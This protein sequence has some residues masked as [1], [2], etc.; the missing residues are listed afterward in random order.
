[1]LCRVQQSQF[2]R[3]SVSNILHVNCF[4]EEEPCYLSCE[5]L[6][7]H[8]QDQT[9]TNEPERWA[10]ALFEPDDLLE[11]RCFPSRQMTTQQEPLKFLPLSTRKRYKLYPW[12]AASRIQDVVNKLLLFNSA[13]G[14]V[15]DWGLWNDSE[16]SWKDIIKLN[17]ISLNVYCSANPRKDQGTKNED[18]ILARSL[19]ADCEYTNAIEVRRKCLEIGL[20]QQ[21]LLVNSGHGI[22][23]YWRLLE[24]IT[25]LEL[26]REFQQ[27]LILALDSDGKVKDPA[28][29]MRL[30]GF[31]NINGKPADCFIVEEN[32]DCRYPLKVFDEVLPKLPRKVTSQRKLHLNGN[33]QADAPCQNVSKVP[34]DYVL[35]RALAYQKTVEPVEEGQRNAIIFRLATS[36]AEYFDLSLDGL[37]KVTTAYNNRLSD[38]LDE[39]ELMLVTEKGH[40]HVISKE[41]PLGTFL[42]DIQIEQLASTDGPEMKLSEWRK[43]MAKS[44]TDS[45]KT[46]K[47]INFDRSPTGAG[48][49]TA[50]LAAITQANTSITFVPTH[51]ACHELVEKL[52]AEGV[53]AAA[54]PQINADTCKRFGNKSNPGEA[55]LAQQAGLDVGESI[56]PGC[57]FFKQC[58]YQEQRAAARNAL[59]AIATQA[60]A[61]HSDFHLAEDKDIIFIHEDARTLLRPLVKV[62]TQGNPSLEDLKNVFRVVQETICISNRMEDENKVDFANHLKVATKRLIDELKDVSMVAKVQEAH[63]AG[64]ITES[65]R[66]IELPLMSPLPRPDRFDYVM[67]RAMQSEGIRPHG[68]ALRLCLGYACGELSHLIA[69]VDD[70]YESQ[71]GKGK[72]KFF[73]SL[74]G[75]WKI[76]PPADKVIW[77]E[78][79]TGNVDLLG[80]LLRRAVCDR[81]PPGRLDWEV[82]PIQYT[83]LDVTQ[84]TSPNV[85][86][87]IIRSLLAINIK[88]KRVGIITHQSH[89]GA[90]NDLEDRWTSRISRMDYF[91]SGNDR[92]S[93]RWLDCDLLIILGTPRVPPSAVRDALVQIGEIDAAAEDGFWGDRLWEAQATDGERKVVIG[94]GYNHPSWHLVHQMLVRD[95]LIQAVGRG[96]GLLTEGVPVVVCSNEPISENIILASEELE[97]LKDPIA[98]TFEA[99]IKL[100]AKNP[101]IHNVGKTAV[102]TNQIASASETQVRQTRFHCHTLSTF[103]LL[104]KK[105]QRGGWIVVGSLAV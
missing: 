59:H 15:T 45:L 6:A 72:P 24:P 49:S 73:K 18:V 8:A 71:N 10:S 16:K 96:R 55:Q 21:T 31:K 22:H 93:N 84:S 61:S 4:D 3:K 32:N 70:I 11:L 23:T 75:V 14:I 56:C 39:G 41:I 35:R 88:V 97:L 77:F 12:I 58:K 52:R 67:N 92:A 60:R 74:I 29:V 102:S 19:F 80:R 5:D 38:P 1:M 94:H 28:R 2:Q 36:L 54:F 25:D 26:W 20:P 7:D 30:P 44:R 43:H 83:N 101:T 46:P 98:T 48:K 17:G 65:K 78:D 53:E 9:L 37:L 62:S 89:L 79:A 69:T 64:T 51:E 50:D 42:Q 34:D 87:G 57:P 104:A 103:G 63:E 40:N 86:R 90:I 100:T 47:T 13:A 99:V 68:N 91:H 85:V 76:D 66:A 33:I 27:R 81:T 105:G 82:R 95:A